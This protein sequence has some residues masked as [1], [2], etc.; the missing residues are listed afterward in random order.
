MSQ[1]ANTSKWEQSDYR[2]IP[3]DFPDFFV[4]LP[5]TTIISKGCKLL[6]VGAMRLLR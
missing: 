6:E 1:A 2:L 5:V 3:T 4:L